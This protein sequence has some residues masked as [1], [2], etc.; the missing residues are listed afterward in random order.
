MRIKTWKAWHDR[1]DVP[2][3]TFLS[4]TEI[5]SPHPCRVV[6]E[7][8]W[9]KVMAVMKAVDAA[10]TFGFDGNTDTELSLAIYD[11]REHERKRK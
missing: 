2:A 10:E 5:Y 3:N 11:L 8:T 4:R 7:A 6:P 9:R 1:N